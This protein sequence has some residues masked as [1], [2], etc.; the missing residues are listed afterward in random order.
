[1]VPLGTW[2]SSM[3][4]ELK[5]IEVKAD[6]EFKKFYEEHRLELQE[7]VN[8]M[9]SNIQISLLLD[10]P[11]HFMSKIVEIIQKNLEKKSTAFFQIRTDFLSDV[12]RLYAV[13]LAQ[14]LQAMS[15][16]LIRDNNYEFVNSITECLMKKKSPEKQ[17]MH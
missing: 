8:T 4:F 15:D 13:L 6:S 16:Y 7:A 12:M 1:M 2:R 5:E 10:I 17:K 9:M 3:D 14:L 11:E